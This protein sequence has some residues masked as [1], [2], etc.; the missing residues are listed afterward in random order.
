MKKLYYT[1]TLLFPYFLF[2]QVGF[3]TSTLN[4]NSAIEIGTDTS[5]KGL[6]LSRI[7]LIDCATASPLTAHEQ[8]MIVYNLATSGSGAL[9]VTPGF[10]YNNGIKFI[11]ESSKPLV[12]ESV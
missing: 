2:S 12:D 5:T 3:G 6:L 7:N 10:Y 9:S 11:R 8:G 4:D 1:L